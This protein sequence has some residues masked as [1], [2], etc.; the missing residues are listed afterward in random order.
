MSQSFLI[1]VALVLVLLE[2]WRGNQAK[3]VETAL[4]KEEKAARKV[5]KE[6]RLAEIH[7]RLSELHARIDELE[8]LNA[9]QNNSST[10]RIL[11]DI[12]DAVD[13]SKSPSGS[14][15][16]ELG[17]QWGSSVRQALGFTPPSPESVAASENAQTGP[18][19]STA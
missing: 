16:T 7:Q 13:K 12:G 15:W 4:K 11:R 2:Y 17:W 10:F 1:T 3:L 19:P 9:R 18:S 14:T 6:A 8:K 5:I